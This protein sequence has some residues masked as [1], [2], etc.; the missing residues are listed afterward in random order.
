[1]EFLREAVIKD[2]PDGLKAVHE[3]L[4]HAFTLP[5]EAKRQLRMSGRTTPEAL[6]V[7]DRMISSSTKTFTPE[8][9]M[10]SSPIL[11]P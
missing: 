8:L 11:R 5:H 2:S 10:I 4:L 1:V 7:I 9:R 6:A 3:Q